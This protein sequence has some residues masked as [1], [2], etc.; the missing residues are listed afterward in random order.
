MTFKEHWLMVWHGYMSYL[1]EHNDAYPN[2]TL[3]TRNWSNWLK[4]NQKLANK[5][6]L[7]AERAE[8]LH[9]LLLET[10]KYRRKNQ[11]MYFYLKQSSEHE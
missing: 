8:K 1:E 2:I 4:Y 6:K 7:C 5:R 9:F 3:I 10:E 11:H